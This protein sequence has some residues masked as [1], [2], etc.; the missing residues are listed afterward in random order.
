MILNYKRWQKIF[1]TGLGIFL[2]A[3]FCMK[4]LEPEF[5]HKGNLFTIIGLEIT[6][7]REKL[8]AIFSE[9]D[10]HV[11]SVLRYHLVFDFVFMIGVYPGIAALCMMAREKRKNKTLRKILL[12]CAVLQILALG[13]DVM[14]NFYLLKWLNV[15]LIGN[16]FI[17]FHSVVAVK[18][19]V[20]LVAAFIAIPLAIK[21]RKVIQ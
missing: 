3:A 18:W 17:F 21:G 10:P 15:P 14:E 9:I 13:C 11:R 5:L 2:A 8:M 6:Y 12:I 20:A 1:L 16:E 4:W 7:P 19:V